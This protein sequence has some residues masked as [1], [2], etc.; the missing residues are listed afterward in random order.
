MCRA[1]A[2]LVKLKKRGHNFYFSVVPVAFAHQ[3]M[4]IASRYAP[5]YYIPDICNSWSLLQGVTKVFVGLEKS[6]ISRTCESPG[7]T[8]YQSIVTNEHETLIPGP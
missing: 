3:L 1:K 4:M 7:Q 5:A 2:N 8:L 6:T